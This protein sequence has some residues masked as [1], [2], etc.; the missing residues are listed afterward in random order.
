MSHPVIQSNSM[1]LVV[2]QLISLEKKFVL[3][4]NCRIKNVY[5]EAAKSVRNAVIQVQN[6][7]LLS[8]GRPCGLGALAVQRFAGYNSE[9]N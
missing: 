9:D 8:I 3:M 2:E 6:Y 4:H 5:R 7:N 1:E